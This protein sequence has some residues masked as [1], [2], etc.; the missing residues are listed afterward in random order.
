MGGKDYILRFQGIEDYINNGEMKELVPDLEIKFLPEG[1]HF[2]QEQSPDEVNQLI[3]TFLAKNVWSWKSQL[4]LLACS[5][6]K[7]WPEFL[8]VWI[9]NLK[10][11]SVISNS[12]IKHFK[13]DIKA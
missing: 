9:S 8:C 1:T 10:D 12:I 5:L 13:C 3:L 11:G 6:P 4:R 7:V 2:V